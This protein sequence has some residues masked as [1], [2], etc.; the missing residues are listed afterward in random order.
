MYAE[1]EDDGITFDATTVTAERIKE[2]ADYQGVRVLLKG[3]LG[4]AVLSVQIDVGFGDAITSHPQLADFPVLLDAPAPRLR[5]YPRETVIAEKLE[6]I[7]HLGIANSRMKDF[8]DV[9]F[10][11]RTF[12]FDGTQLTAAIRATFER[13]RTP[14]PT[15]DPVAFTNDA[16]KKA[17]WNGFLKRTGIVGDPPSLAEVVVELRAFLSEP[18]NTIRINSPIERTWSRGRWH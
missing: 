3:K 1:V 7:V 15:G 9:A 17:Q 10:L 13:R 2:D 8:F 14:I 5:I 16:Q 12:E 11:A 6:A 18:L 4:S